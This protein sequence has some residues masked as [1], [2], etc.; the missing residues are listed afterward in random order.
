MIPVKVLAVQFLANAAPSLCK[1]LGAK[2]PCLGFLTTDCDDATYL[3]LDAATKAAQV[4]VAYGRSFY[5]GAA[6]ATTPHAGEVL[7][8]LSGPTPGAVKSGMEAALSTLKTV[9]FE[10]IRGVPCFAQ[11]VSSVG[12]FL[13]KEAGVK[14][15]SALAYLI[16]PPLES[17][18]ALDGAMKAADVTLRKL[19]APPTETN[20]GGGLLS[21]TQSACQSA[22]DAFRQA[23]AEVAERPERM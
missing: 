14:P 7:G 11:T 3:A 22:C 10:E 13:A 18:V 19:Y 20:F 16:A 1:A 23:V 17:M 5:G 15:G 9:G 21:G 12:T 6:N 8:I 2:S 4:E